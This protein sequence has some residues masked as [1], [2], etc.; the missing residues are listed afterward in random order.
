MGKGLARALTDEDAGGAGI[1]H[2]AAGDQIVLPTLHIDAQAS[3]DF[4]GQAA[5]D[6][7][8]CVDQAE[9]RL[10]EHGDF[11]ERLRQ[12]AW[13]VEIEQPGGTVEIPF[14]GAVKLFEQVHGNVLVEIFTAADA[15]DVRLGQGDA[16]AES[17]DRS[18]LDLVVGKSVFEGALQPDVLILQPAG[19]AVIGIEKNA[20]AVAIVADARHRAGIDHL[21]DGDAAVVGISRQRHNLMIDVQLQRRIDHRQAMPELPVLS[22]L[23][24]AEAG[25]ID[26][27]DFVA[28]PGIE[29]LSNVLRGDRNKSSCIDAHTA[30]QPYR[31]ARP[32]G[33]SDRRKRFAGIPL[34]Q[35]KSFSQGVIA[36][37]E[38]DGK[39]VRWVSFF[40]LVFSDRIPGALQCG[41]RFFKSAR[42]LI[43]AAARDIVIA[44]QD[45]L[46]QQ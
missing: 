36:A 8:R 32:R 27:K 17:V 19:V 5:D 16:P 31:F 38:I 14:A 37:A 41:E 1:A 7:V 6:H 44:R 43:A 28:N 40:L 25:Q 26:L 35:F 13:R 9:Q 22:V 21:A 34:V 11:D 2:R 23:G 42:I 33:V 3:S 24:N 39:A 18:D 4:N 10:L 46:S 29:P 15:I 30:D 12:I 20:A 45:G